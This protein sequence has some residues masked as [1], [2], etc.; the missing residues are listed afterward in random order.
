MDN[1]A[2]VEKPIHLLQPGEMTQYSNHWYIGCPGEGCLGIGNLSN[3]GVSVLDGVVTITP[4]VL[5]SCGAHYFVE[6]NAIRW[7]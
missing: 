3:H 1:I 4:S 6:N 2:I 5:C 7:C